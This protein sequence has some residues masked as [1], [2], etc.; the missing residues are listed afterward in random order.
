[1]PRSVSASSL[2]Q[3]CDGPS[4]SKSDASDVK[5]RPTR[6]PDSSRPVRSASVPAW[7]SRTGTK[8]GCLIDALLYLSLFAGFASER[9]AVR[10][11]AE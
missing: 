11:L 4:V 8:H 5:A 10:L 1:M 6:S 3:C 9:A 7:L 2:I